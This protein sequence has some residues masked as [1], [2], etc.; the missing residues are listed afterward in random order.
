MW[1]RTMRKKERTGMSWL[2]WPFDHDRI[3]PAFEPRDGMDV[4][5]GPTSEQPDIC[6]RLLTKVERRSMI[7]SRVGI[8][9]DLWVRVLS[10][11]HI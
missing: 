6:Y 11:I 2:R 9:R 1:C 10:L 3:P 5:N 8:A 4:A 7:G